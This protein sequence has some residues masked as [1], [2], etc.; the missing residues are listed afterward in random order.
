MFDLEFKILFFKR[1]IKEV[2]PSPHLPVIPNAIDSSLSKLMIFRLTFSIEL[3]NTNKSSSTLLIETSSVNAIFSF[4]RFFL[5][6]TLFNVNNSN[7]IRQ[8]KINMS[9]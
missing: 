7:G 2:L 3:F 1:F 5:F 6:F 9:K 8:I 4:C